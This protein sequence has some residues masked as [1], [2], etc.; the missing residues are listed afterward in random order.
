MDA[1][2]GGNSLA[3]TLINTGRY[4]FEPVSPVAEYVDGFSYPKTSHD[5][6][7]ALMIVSLKEVWMTVGSS[8]YGNFDTINIT[9][10][11]SGSTYAGY[12]RVIDARTF[13]VASPN[14]QYYGAP[15]IGYIYEV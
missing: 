5:I 10:G 12:I 8:I 9:T 11:V 6:Y 1:L 14:S 15:P 7:L 2:F 4:K 13:S 3:A